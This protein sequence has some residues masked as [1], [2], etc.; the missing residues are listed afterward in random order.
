MKDLAIGLNVYARGVKWITII[1]NVR[2]FVCDTFFCMLARQ[3]T[4]F[5][6]IARTFFGPKVYCKTCITIHCLKLIIV[7]WYKFTEKSSFLANSIFVHASSVT[8]VSQLHLVMYRSCSF[9]ISL[10]L[11]PPMS[12]LSSHTNCQPNY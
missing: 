2:P 7:Y 11:T 3:A 5:P 1:L 8:F 4:N 10:S 6:N 9:S 12:I